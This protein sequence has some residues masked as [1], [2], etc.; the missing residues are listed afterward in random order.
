[1]WKKG[2]Y[3]M[4]AR[5]G[6]NQINRSTNKIVKTVFSQISKRGTRISN[7]LRNTE[8]EILSG[9][10][11][12]RV[13]KKANTHGDR[14]SKGTKSL[15]GDYGHKLKKGQLYRASAP[16]EAPASDSGTLRKSFQAIKSK[17]SSS[18]GIK[19][20]A[21]IETKEKYAKWLQNGTE[22]MAPRPFVKPILEKAKPEVIRILNEPYIK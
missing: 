9:T 20:A 17:E 6:A 12:G 14:K 21:G 15:M 10:R 11:S 22:K 19:V 18:K 2:F 5:E 16:G 7:V 3:E 13:Y 4:N 8:I 1:M